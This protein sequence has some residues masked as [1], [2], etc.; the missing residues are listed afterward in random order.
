MGDVLSLSAVNNKLY[1]GFQD[2]RIRCTELEV[3]T[4]SKPKQID[5]FEEELSSSPSLGLT[6]SLSGSPRRPGAKA[7]A[8]TRLLSSDSDV[9][10]TPTKCVAPLPYRPMVA[11]AS[12][13]AFCIGDTRESPVD[14]KVFGNSSH[15]G[16][17]SN[18]HMYRRHSTY[19]FSFVHCLIV[20]DNK[21]FSGAGDGMI[22]VWDLA[23]GKCLASLSGHRGSVLALVATT[24]S[25]LLSG[26]RFVDC[27][28][29]LQIFYCG[30]QRSY[31]QALGCAVG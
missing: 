21:M 24:D 4:E 26:S 22:K 20:R 2:T 23:T 12:Q 10:C 19:I 29:A 14:L 30:H 11:S 16:Y 15:F 28:C 7:P 8:K 31:D 13:L 5:S 6:L 27:V 17:A 1:V 25:T 18:Y 9:P 3:Y